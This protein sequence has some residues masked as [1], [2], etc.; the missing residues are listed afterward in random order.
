MKFSI[1]NLILRLRFGK[2]KADSSHL[3]RTKLFLQIKFG[4]MKFPEMP[5]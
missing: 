4:K 1:L 2:N 5:E 3:L